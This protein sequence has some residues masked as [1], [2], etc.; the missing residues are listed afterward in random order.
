MTHHVFL[1]G[2]QIFL[3]FVKNTLRS[4]RWDFE[5][6]ILCTISCAAAIESIINEILQND[7]RIKGWDELKIKSKIENIASFNNHK[8]EW[9]NIH[10]QTVDD[11]IKARNYL[12]HFKGENLGLFGTPHIEEMTEN[13]TLIKYNQSK[14][15]IST[16]YD[17]SR[18]A[19]KKRYE[20][21]LISLIELSS[22][23]KDNNQAY[24]FLSSENYSNFTIY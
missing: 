19:T 18:E 21:L 16:K 3:S 9:G 24:E 17:F 8:I 5:S 23:V 22:C 6:G 11:V 12:V 2:S 15:E 13:F 20:S 10:W 1:N 4:E 7:G 14:K